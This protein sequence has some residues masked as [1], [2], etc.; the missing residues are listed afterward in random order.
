MKT[1]YVWSFIGV[2]YIY[3]TYIDGKWRLIGKSNDPGITTWTRIVYTGS[4]ALQKT[5]LHPW[6][7]TWHWKIPIFNRKYIFKWWMFYCHVSFRGGKESQDQ[8]LQ[9]RAKD[10][11]TMVFYLGV[12]LIMVGRNSKA[13]QL[14]DLLKWI[15]NKR[16]HPQL[17]SKTLEKKTTLKIWLRL[18][19]KQRWYFQSWC[20]RNSKERTWTISQMCSPK[21]SLLTQDMVWVDFTYKHWVLQGFEG[22]Q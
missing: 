13:F 7:P 19:E 14:V 5:E 11:I 10:H 22:L 9:V 8:I 17:E 18:G 20:L 16:H 12:I 4:Q 1:I 2:L 15:W 3:I 6:K 21:A